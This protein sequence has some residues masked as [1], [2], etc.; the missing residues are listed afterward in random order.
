MAQGPIS[1]W[2]RRRLDELGRM[3]LRYGLSDEGRTSRL[4]RRHEGHRVLLGRV[5][6][7][8]AELT[9]EQRRL[10]QELAGLEKAIGLSAEDEALSIAETQGEGWSPQPITGFRVW[11]LDQGLLRGARQAWPK[12]T[13]AARCSRGGPHEVPH[14]DGRCGRLGCGIYAARDLGA[15]LG[16]PNARTRVSAGVVALSG[17]VV[18]HEGGYR[19]AR[20]QVIAIGLVAGGRSL[21]AADRESITRVFADPLA[22]LAEFG[23]PGRGA[24]PGIREYLIEKERQTWT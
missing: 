1:G 2:A 23:M 13:L 7:R 3:R 16:G 21:V 5:E 20:A 14:T 11:H 6:E 18:E 19:G 8:L 24:W 10:E 22:A 9:A 17:K 12:P 4:L 15:L